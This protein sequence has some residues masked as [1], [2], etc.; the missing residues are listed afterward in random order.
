MPGVEAM[1]DPKKSAT[2][3]DTWQATVTAR[4]DAQWHDEMGEPRSK[5]C[6]ADYQKPARVGVLIQPMTP[7][8]E[9]SVTAPE[10]NFTCT[11]DDGG[12]DPKYL[13]QAPFR[14]PGQRGAPG[15]A[16][17][18]RTFNVEPYTVTVSYKM[19]PR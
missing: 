2:A 9:V 15:P 10:M 13:Q 5:S 1:T 3:Y 11:G 19:A 6:A 8:Y 7:T 12:P 18:T 17:G 16:N 4:L 14:V